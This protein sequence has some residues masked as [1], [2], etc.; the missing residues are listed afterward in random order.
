MKR[1]EHHGAD[2]LLGLS[3]A[4]IFMLFILLTWISSVWQTS[5]EAPEGGQSPQQMVSVPK[6]RLAALED[7]SR[8]F[9]GFSEVVPPRYKDMPIEQFRETV[10]A[11]LDRAEKGGRGALA[12]VD[13]NNVLFDALVRNGEVEVRLSSASP[14]TALESLERLNGRRYFPGETLRGA[15]VNALLAALKQ[16]QEKEGCVFDYRL[17]YLTLEDRVLGDDK[18]ERACY[19]YRRYPLEK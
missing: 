11:A 17:Y 10:K 19:L 8:K 4:E 3:L 1:R 14:Q 5:P 9:A 12:C 6:E 16:K 15:E 13:G 7:I 2:L 18:F